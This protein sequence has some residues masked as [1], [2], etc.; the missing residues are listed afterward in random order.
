MDE[1]GDYELV[2]KLYLSHSHSN[3]RKFKVFDRGSILYAALPDAD[4]NTQN[5]HETG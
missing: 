2:H 1:K 4:V 5:Q 3:S